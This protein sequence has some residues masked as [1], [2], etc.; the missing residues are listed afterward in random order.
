MVGLAGFFALGAV[1]LWTAVWTVLLVREAARTW[2]RH[3]DDLP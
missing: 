1:G 3:T 2:R